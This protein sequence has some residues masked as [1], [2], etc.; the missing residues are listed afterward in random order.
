MADTASLGL[1]SR[2]VHDAARV[3]SFT[4]ARCL[5]TET[6]AA[7][8]PAAF[9]FPDAGLA[10]KHH[11]AAVVGQPF[12]RPKQCRHLALTL[13]EGVT[14]QVPLRLID[15]PRHRVHPSDQPR[16]S[17]PKGRAAPALARISSTVVALPVDK[18]SLP[19]DLD[20]DPNRRSASRLEKRSKRDRRIRGTRATQ[21]ASAEYRIRGPERRISACTR[22]ADV[23]RDPTGGHV[24]GR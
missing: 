19:A 12:D 10:A 13:H 8:D 9:S 6:E 7:A 2:A 15:R 16:L 22:H 17:T 18:K 14:K 21:N 4:W 24:Q 5:V 23:S 11:Q 3:D 1:P 20:G